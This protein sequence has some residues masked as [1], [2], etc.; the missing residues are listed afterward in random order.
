[1]LHDPDVALLVGVLDP[2]VAF[3]V[4]VSWPA[5]LATLHRLFLTRV[6]IACH[7]NHGT[8]TGTP[9]H[10]LHLAS[11]LCVCAAYLVIGSATDLTTWSSP[12]ITKLP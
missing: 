12:V 3:G 7:T 2:S 6:T 10:A 11:P 1:M 4:L 5:Y 8:L 9:C